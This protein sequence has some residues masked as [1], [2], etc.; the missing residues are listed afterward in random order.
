MNDTAASANP[1]AESRRKVARQ[2]V[3]PFARYKG[4]SAWTKDRRRVKAYALYRASVA[5][6]ATAS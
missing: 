1:A 5:K 4:T 3:P 6:A 2:K